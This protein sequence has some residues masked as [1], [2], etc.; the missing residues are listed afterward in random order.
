MFDKT[1]ILKKM[2]DICVLCLDSHEIGISY[3]FC[4]SQRHIFCKECTRA[5]FGKREKAEIDHRC[6]LCRS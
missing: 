5:L 4:P 6:P 1:L 3:P 2:K